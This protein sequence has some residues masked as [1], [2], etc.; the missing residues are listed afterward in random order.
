[1]NPNIT[2]NIVI[3]SLG[4]RIKEEKGNNNNKKL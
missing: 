4:K 2:L 1:M 3:K